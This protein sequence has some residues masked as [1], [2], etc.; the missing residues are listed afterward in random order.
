MNGIPTN[1]YYIEDIDERDLADICYI[2]NYITAKY[3]HPRSLANTHSRQRYYLIYTAGSS[4]IAGYITVGGRIPSY[5]TYFDGTLN[6]FLDSLSTYKERYE[7]WM[8]DQ[9][10]TAIYGERIYGER[11]KHESD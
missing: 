7:K 6:Q 1:V 3:I 4:D 11:R 5:L 10:N 9:L 2:H 8:L